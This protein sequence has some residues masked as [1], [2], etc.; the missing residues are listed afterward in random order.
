MG[1]SETFFLRGCHIHSQ[2]D[3]GNL[4]EPNV[5]CNNLLNII[6]E[7]FSQCMKNAPQLISNC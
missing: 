7:R 3:H 2:H 5:P 1:R 4:M 6:G